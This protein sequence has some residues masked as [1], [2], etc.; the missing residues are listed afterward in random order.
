MIVSLA[1][2]TVVAVIAIGAFLKITD[3][4]KKS[5]TLKTTINNLS[6]TLESMSREMRVGSTYYCIQSSGSTV[7]TVPAALVA[8]SC[9]VTANPA[10]NRPW[11]VA[12]RSSKAGVGVTIPTCN[13]IY[14]Y[15]FQRNSV[16][17]NA[18]VVK[19]AQQTNCDNAITATSYVDLVS[20]D[21]KFTGM[22]VLVTPASATNQARASF[23]FKGYAGERLRERT[24]F[25]VQ[26]SVSQRSTI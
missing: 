6:F 25:E 18:F 10:I 26:T 15:L 12:F 24:E 3:S 16:D 2:F 17:S 14:S 1:L 23:W 21:V 20:P 5:Q 7:P 13:L 9:D 8:G 19:K 11:V 22:K 4:N